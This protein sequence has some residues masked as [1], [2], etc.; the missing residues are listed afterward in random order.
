MGEYFN[1][2]N[3]DKKEYLCPADFDL[4]NKLHESMYR[5]NAILSALHSLLS[6]EWRGDR[7]LFLGDECKMPIDPK[8]EVLQILDNETRQRKTGHYYDTVVEN[9]RNVSCLFKEA[10]A[11]VRQGIDYY[12]KKLGNSSTVSH[13]TNEYGI[14]IDHPFDGLFLKCGKNYRYTINYTKKVYYSLDFTKILHLDRSE[15]SNADP[16]PLLMGYGRSASL[17]SWLGDRIGV[18]DEVE[19]PYTQ[20]EEI[21]LDW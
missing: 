20:I 18:A 8:Y 7:I 1:W 2:V 12:I 14:N 9:Y 4:G 11:E 10:E 16:L 13:D 5:G 3:V 19:G 15:N 17:G 6:S 21:M